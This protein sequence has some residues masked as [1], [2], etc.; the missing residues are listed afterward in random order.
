MALKF[1]D[2][3]VYGSVSDA[4]E[5]IDDARIK[6]ARI[7][8]ASWGDYNDFGST[9]LR[10]AI[11]SARDVGIIFVAAA[12]NDGRNLDQANF[13][14]A[15]F[16]LDNTIVVGATTRTD[17]LALWSNYGARNVDLAAPGL[18]VYGCWSTG[19]SSYQGFTGTSVSAPLVAGACALVW[20]RFPHF[21]YRDVIQE[22]SQRWIRCQHWQG[23]A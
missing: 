17:E 18:D 19:D 11:A 23:G 9:A 4:I 21:S 7:I 12:G 15:N 6:G 13:F 5:C 14:P 1:F 2:T 3:A 16:E 20:A 8:N 22:C 10:D